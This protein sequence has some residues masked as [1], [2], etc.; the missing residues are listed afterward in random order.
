MF[1]W[2][3][4]APEET[5]IE[6]AYED[7]P[8]PSTHEE[9]KAVAHQ[10]SQCRL[11]WIKSND[12]WQLFCE[13]E[14]GIVIEQREVPGS[15][16]HL[17]RARGVLKQ[18]DLDK[19]FH[20]QLHG[21]IAVRKQLSTDILAH[22]MLTKLDDGSTYVSYSAYS[23]PLGVS[24]RE[25][26]TM[27]HHQVCEDGSHLITI[28]SVNHEKKPFTPGFVRGSTRGARFFR[29]LETPGDYELILVDHVDPRG[30]IPGFVINQFKRKAGEAIRK[31]QDI[32]S[33]TL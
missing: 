11:E 30:M 33:N 21:G 20:D 7:L 31:V 9:M 13:M 5:V 3:R 10:E 32:Y 25:F 17:I 22:E 14:G 16:I 1:S 4:R 18:I 6:W 23:T 2:A 8:S 27:R 28:Q 12:G 15:S 29:P 24:N 19:M 26:V